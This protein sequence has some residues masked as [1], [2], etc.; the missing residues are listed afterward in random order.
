MLSFVF[1][2]VVLSVIMLSVNILSVVVPNVVA[3]LWHSYL[4]FIWKSN[5]IK[6]KL[7]EIIIKIVQSH[8]SF[9]IAF[10][11]LPDILESTKRTGGFSCHILV[12]RY[13][14]FIE[15]SLGRKMKISFD[16]KLRK[17]FVVVH[18]LTKNFVIKNENH[19]GKP[20]KPLFSVAISKWFLNSK[21]FVI[22]WS[23]IKWCFLVQISGLYY[24][25]VT[26]VIYDRNDSVQ[27][28][29]TTITIVIDDP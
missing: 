3:P 16:K 20:Y 11:P 19:F 21:D 8:W 10:N 23:I 2:N 29:K 9:K 27:Y 7:S 6:M 1:C 13:V 25:H 18:K 28:H 14:C 4:M 17:S 26:I 15:Q 22:R 12:I 24:K 5:F